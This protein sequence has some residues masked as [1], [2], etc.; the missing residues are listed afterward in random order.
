MIV[1]R[2][3][4]NLSPLKL[5][6]FYSTDGQHGPG[7]YFTVEDAV[8]KSFAIPAE[9]GFGIIATYFLDLENYSAFNHSS[10]LNQELEEI[11][12]NIKTLIEQVLNTSLEN[13]EDEGFDLDYRDFLLNQEKF[14]EHNPLVKEIKDL[15]ES[16]LFLQER[17]KH[18][19]STYEVEITPH[20]YAII[21]R[22]DFIPFSLLSFDLNL[23]QE[24][25]AKEVFDLLKVGDQQGAWIKD[26]PSEYCSQVAK[27]L[28]K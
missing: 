21:V 1:K 19:A 25:R 24:S 17:I 3:T 11:K 10:P 8:A 15:H 27:I 5:S 7:M 16:Y 18:L 20:N 26:I 28:S 4:K 22:Q 2:G 9:E 14:P 12:E 13:L 6:E 23:L